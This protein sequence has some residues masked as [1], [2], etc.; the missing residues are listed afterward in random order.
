MHVYSIYI[1]SIHSLFRKHWSISKFNMY[2]FIIVCFNRGRLSFMQ[3]PR[4]QFYMITPHWEFVMFFLNYMYHTHLRIMC[5][6]A[7]YLSY[8]ENII[9]TLSKSY[10][11]DD[12][13][14]FCKK[15]L[16]YEIIVG[17]FLNKFSQVPHG[18]LTSWGTYIS[19]MHVCI[20]ILF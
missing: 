8:I 20:F 13:L 2:L 4:L 6:Y 5:S 19:I 17:I 15:K 7:I 16:I 11:N 14:L 10:A 12:F 1:K 18:F 9:E 3:W